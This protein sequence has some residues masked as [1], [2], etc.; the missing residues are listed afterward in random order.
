MNNKVN[1]SCDP[2]RW[3]THCLPDD[4]PRESVAGGIAIIVDVLRASTTIVT[5]LEAGAAFV[6]PVVKVAEARRLRSISGETCLL[7]GERRGVRIAGFDLGNSPAE[8][9]RAAVEGRGIVMTTTNGTL[10]IE[11]SLAAKV[12]LVGSFLNRNA[13]AKE[14]VLLA[15]ALD[16]HVI[17]LVCAGTN[18]QETEED[19]LG[20]GSIVHA[21]VS[22]SSRN[23]VLDSVSE[24]ALAGFSRAVN[25]SSEPQ[26]Q[27]VESFRQSQGGKNLITLGMESDL[28]LAAALDRC[29]LV[30]RLCPKSGQLMSF[31]A[32]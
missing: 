1:S 27:L 24:K 18:G 21:G 16:I 6:K 22:E 9:C 5:A 4:M 17:H 12:V 13:V 31:D 8:Y 10:A 20:A 28:V 32:V 19:F 15:S 23:H 30:P 29:S 25:K 2:L 7:G 3:Y 14:A 26:S 11:R